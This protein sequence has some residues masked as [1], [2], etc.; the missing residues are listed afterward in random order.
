MVENPVVGNTYKVVGNV[1]DT[2]HT[3]HSRKAMARY[4]NE[5]YQ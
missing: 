2:G 3:Y 5:V 4:Y 1:D